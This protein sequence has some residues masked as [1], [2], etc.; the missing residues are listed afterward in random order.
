MH[1]LQ[2]VCDAR[3]R[4][5]IARRQLARGRECIDRNPVA[6]ATR[7][8]RLRKPHRKRGV[9]IN[10]TL[11]NHFLATVRP[12]PG[13]EEEFSSLQQLLPIS[14][15]PSL[16]FH[17]PVLCR[18]AVFLIETNASLSLSLNRSTVILPLIYSTLALL[19]TVR[20]III[21]IQALKLRPLPSPTPSMSHRGIFNKTHLLSLP[22]LKSSKDC[23][24][25][26]S[27][28]NAFQLGVSHPSAMDYFDPSAL[29]LW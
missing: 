2:S 10:R 26:L 25:L 12:T 15:P 21:I 20:D 11:S 8:V 7:S 17:P 28:F 6:V 5:I 24:E 29:S 22:G 19:L 13:E 16:R 3:G 9:C 1:L 14:P 27:Y 23:V 18:L 4:N